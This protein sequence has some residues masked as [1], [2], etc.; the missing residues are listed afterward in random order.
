MIWCT[1]A[2]CLITICSYK[3][4]SLVH[5]KLPM[6]MNVCTDTR[7]YLL[8][9]ENQPSFIEIHYLLI[10]HDGF[11]LDSRLEIYTIFLYHF[12]SLNLTYT[13][14]KKKK[15]KINIFNDKK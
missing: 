3:S 4:I 9:N 6:P 12:P 15:K 14:K 10:N 5:A 2:A 13:Q 1:A 11:F 8:K 7:E